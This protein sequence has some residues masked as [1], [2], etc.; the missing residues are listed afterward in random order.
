M[1]KINTLLFMFLLEFLVVFL[2]LAIY[3][4]YKSMNRFSRRSNPD[5]G[6]EGFIEDLKR[7]VE[8]LEEESKEYENKGEGEVEQ[9][10]IVDKEINAAKLHLIYT[11]LA[12][13]QTGNL[14]G[15]ALWEDLYA[16]FGGI[17]R[18]GIA[19]AL[20]RI[21][22]GHQSVDS[23]K[24]AAGSQRNEA[25]E[26]KKVMQSS[27][28]TK[29]RFIIELLGHKE[30]VTELEKELIKLREMNQKLIETLQEL[31]D[32][33]PKQ[34]ASEINNVNSRVDKLITTIKQE[35]DMFSRQIEDYELVN[36]NRHGSDD[37]DIDK[38]PSVY[39]GTDGDKEK[40]QKVIK[41]LESNLNVL[42]KKIQELES[43]VT[44]KEAAYQKLQQEF[45]ALDAEFKRL[46]GKSDD[47]LPDD[48]ML[49]IKIKEMEAALSKKEVAYNNL[50]KQFSDLEQEYD[51]LYSSSNPSLGDETNFHVKIKEME[52]ELAKKD[53]AY[54]NLQKEFSDLEQEYDRL[55]SSSNPSLGDET[56]LHTKVKELEENLSQKDTAYQ[57]LQ[58]EFSDLEQEYDRLYSSSNPSLGD[59]TNFHAK[60][61]ELEEEIARKD[62]AFNNLQKQY[63]DL[64]K[65]HKKP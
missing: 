52:E 46:Y 11:A 6:S 65:E 4:F 9:A 55:Y 2:G 16:R 54:Q 57:N 13:A 59:E 29:K 37:L 27:A 61:K 3:F 24:M 43:T 38:V 18:E 10:T 42:T 58:K 23:E 28:A 22:T 26:S 50:Q 32:E 33:S 8:N 49:P 20:E 60:I 17:I 44:K 64:E 63:N 5:Q 53:T 30:M 41:S 48:S 21:K 51:R 31:T 19:N 1:I 25:V 40:M 34:V 62:D 7:E 35:S 15:A 14:G 47:E 12:T 39:G 45:D 36:V 56:N